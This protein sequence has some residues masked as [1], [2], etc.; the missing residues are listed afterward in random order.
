MGPWP[1]TPWPR[2]TQPTRLQEGRQTRLAPRTMSDIPTFPNDRT[3]EETILILTSSV[4]ES[5]KA[6]W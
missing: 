1:L 2:R 4:C 5:Q 3:C 6:A